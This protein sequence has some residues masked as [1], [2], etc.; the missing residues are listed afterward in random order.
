MGICS[1]LHLNISGFLNIFMFGLERVNIRN[2]NKLRLKEE[3]FFPIKKIKKKMTE[4]EVVRMLQDL[5]GCE[6]ET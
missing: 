4:I 6:I 2:K 5:P 1:C 3:H